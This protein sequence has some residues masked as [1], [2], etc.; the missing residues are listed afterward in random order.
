[1]QT[2]KKI[3]LLDFKLSKS[4]WNLLFWVYKS[5]FYGTGM[6]F[7]EHREYSLWD[8]V[9]YIDWKASARWEKTY[10]KVFEQ[11]RDLRVLFLLDLNK[12]MFFE[13][14]K[15]KKLDILEEVFYA[16]SFSV[17]KNND[18][19]ACFTFWDFNTEF[20]PYAKEKWNIFKVLDFIEKTSPLAPPLEERG[21]G[22]EKILEKI[23]K[24]NAKNNLIFILSDDLDAEKY[25]KYLKNIWIKN[26]I[27]FF[28][29]SDYFEKNLEKIPVDLWFKNNKD[30]LNFSLNNEKKIEEYKKLLK[31]K[32]EKF[33]NIMKKHNIKTIFLD[34]KMD[35]FREI[36]KNFR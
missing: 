31:E 7:A 20:F 23:V 13:F 28:H 29:I 32:Q 5:K 3:K 35:I 27:I 1:M 22:I 12:S 9:K 4:I 21:I 15:R 17:Y 30:F 8:S 18:S 6:D 10:L 19:F 34:T 33:E 16:L 36:L 26:E 14:E 25:E 11:D 2:T 24:D